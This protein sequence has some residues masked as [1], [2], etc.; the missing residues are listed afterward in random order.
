MPNDS[1]GSDSVLILIVEDDPSTLEIMVRMLEGGG[2]RCATAL[3]GADGVN[4]ARELRPRVVLMNVYMPVMGGFEAAKE[5]L[6]E[7]P[8]CQIVFFSGAATS[9]DLTQAESEMGRTF[10]PLLRKPFTK[11]ALLNL[12]R[13]CVQ[14]DGPNSD[15][16][17]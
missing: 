11:D 8:N 7:Q 6:D 12:V 1:I 4:V 2:Y 5:I 13:D 10:R 16:L 3:H 15:S 14:A 9:R 17:T